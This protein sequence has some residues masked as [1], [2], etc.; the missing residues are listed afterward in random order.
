MNANEREKSQKSEKIYT[1]ED[2]FNMLVQIYLG[3]MKRPSFYKDNNH[4]K[5]YELA[6]KTIRARIEKDPERESYY[7]GM[8]DIA[9]RFYEFVSNPKMRDEIIKNDVKM[10]DFTRLYREEIL[11]D[12]KRQYDMSK[13]FKEDYIA[14]AQDKKTGELRRKVL[15]MAK[16]C[17]P[18]KYADKRGNEITIEEIGKLYMEE[19]NGIK[20]DITRYRIQK[21]ISEN[22]YMIYE[23]FSNIRICDMENPEYREAVLQELLSDNNMT[24]ANAGGYIG[25][26]VKTPKELEGVKIGEET[27]TKVNSYYYKIG[28]EYSLEYNPTDLSAVMLHDREQKRKEKEEQKKAIDLLPGV[29]Y[30]DKER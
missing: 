14:K 9:N 20:S 17:T 11:G 18:H 23:V 28:N 4:Y 6:V 2:F 19:W 24:L 10:S 8:F 15:Y 7:W 16:T 29:S 26:I 5:I 12:N 21:L 1:K 22:Q 3:Q 13:M 25:E 30:P 27:T